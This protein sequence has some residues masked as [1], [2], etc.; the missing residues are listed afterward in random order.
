MDVKAVN[1]FDLL[2]AHLIVHFT[3]SMLHDIPVICVPDSYR[4][5]GGTS[6]TNKFRIFNPES[7]MSI[8]GYSISKTSFLKFEQCQKAFFLYKNH[9]YLRDKFSIDKQLTFKRGHDVGYF[10]QQLFSGGIDVSKEVKGSAA[11]AELTKAL[12]ENKTEVI[13]EATFIYNGVLIM[14]DI[15]TLSEGKYTAYEVKSSMKISETYL[16]DAY[17]QYYVLKNSLENFDDLFLVTINPDYIRDE[18]IDSKKLFRKRS[19]KIKAEENFAYFEHQL[20]SAHSILEQNVIPNIAIG[21]QCFRPY[22]CDYFGSCWKDTVTEDSIFNLPYIDKNKL[23]EWYNNGIKTIADVTDELIEKPAAL[24]I[25]KSFVNN[26]PIVDKEKIIEFLMKIQGTVIAMDMEIWS[27]AIPQLTGTK[28]FEQ[29]PFLVS[30]Y[31][32]TETSH[33]FTGHTADDRRA[34]AEHL[35]KLSSAYNTI[36]VYD[37]TMEVMT[38]NSLVHKYPDLSEALNALKSKLVDVFEIFLELAYY[39]PSFKS[40]FSLKVVSAILLQDVSYSKITSGLEAMNYFE[41]YRLADNEIEK[42]V[43]K[44]ELIEYCNTDTVATFKLAEFMRKLV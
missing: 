26:E 41:Q 31:N 22:Q 17:L 42:E 8:P 27:A 44:S 32:G 13:Y 25:K 7:F 29:V 18:E 15:L 12:I 40:N 16:K 10:A 9:P 23:F 33:F 14:A 43:F 20:N 19:V 28:P 35:I 6:R 2:S 37:K 38:I 34:F 30:F 24:K 1:H 11:G 4:N 39:N 3:F 36:L 5:N 21:K